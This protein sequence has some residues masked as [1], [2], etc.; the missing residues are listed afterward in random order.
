MRAVLEHG[1]FVLSKLKIPYSVE[2]RVGLLRNERSLVVKFM[3]QNIAFRHHRNDVDE[4]HVRIHKG[5]FKIDTDFQLMPSDRQFHL[6]SHGKRFSVYIETVF[7]PVRH[8][9]RGAARFA[10]HQAE[11]L[12]ERRN[13][14]PSVIGR[15]ASRFAHHKDGIAVI[16][17]GSY[18]A[19]VIE[20]PLLFKHCGVQHE[21]IGI[22][23]NA[24]VVVVL[25]KHRGIRP[26]SHQLHKAR[27][28]ICKVDDGARFAV[29]F[30]N[31]SE[32]LVYESIYRLLKLEF[33]RMAPAVEDISVVQLINIFFFFAFIGHIHQTELVVRRPVKLYIYRARPVETGGAAVH[34]EPEICL[35]RIGRKLRPERKRRDVEGLFRIISGAREILAFIVIKQVGGTTAQSELGNVNLRGR[36]TEETHRQNRE[37]FLGSVL[38]RSLVADRIFRRAVR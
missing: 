24:R 9:H 37:G 15:D 18:D 4:D 13:G 28:N 21:V 3:H 12:V 23:L 27:E 11:Q 2:F 25:C 20:A 19:G 14:E 17:Y 5:A 30:C 10:V 6:L 26:A 32:R 38:D 16:P 22:N 7:I 35:R 1:F 33:Q 36:L 29:N 34:H 31:E 8:N